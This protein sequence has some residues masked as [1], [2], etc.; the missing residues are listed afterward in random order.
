M[1]ITPEQLAVILADHKLWLAGKGGSRAD[2][3]GADLS[4][5]K[6]ILRLPVSDPRGYEWVAVN[7]P[8]GWRRSNRPSGSPSTGSKNT[9]GGG[10]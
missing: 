4:R 7:G 2:L 8:G 1:K 5:A 10:Q 3:T 6:N 9:A